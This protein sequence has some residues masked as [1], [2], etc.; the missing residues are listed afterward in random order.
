MPKEWT[1]R[2]GANLTTGKSPYD[3][4]R[5][6]N[7]IVEVEPYSYARDGA[8]IV[9]VGG[10]IS[11]SGLPNLPVSQQARVEES[12]GDQ[13]TIDTLASL[14]LWIDP[15]APIF[16]DV[17][18]NTAATTGDPVGNV[19]CYATGN[20]YTQ[21]NAA[22]KPTLA[23][24][25]VLTGGWTNTL[26][27][28]PGST[29]T[30]KLIIATDDGI[31]VADA[32]L[33]SSFTIRITPTNIRGIFAG[34][35]TAGDIA[36]LKSYAVAEGAVDDNFSGITNFSNY[37]RNLSFLLSIPSSLDTSSGENFSL[38]WYYCSNLTSF[39]L[40]DTSSGTNFNRA[41]E[42]CSGLTS[43]PLLN[44]S[45]VIN[46]QRCWFGCSSLVSFPLIDTSSG[47]N[48]DETWSTCPGLTSFP[49]LDV[50]SGTSFTA[51]WRNCSNLT[52]FPLLDTS[53]GTN[54]SFTWQN[55]SGLTSF[56]LLDVSSGEDFRFAW[57]DCSSLAS[58]PLLDVSSGTDF[59]STWRDCSSLANFPAN[60]FD[61]CSATSFD[62]AFENTA[63]TQT[64]I[65]N[66]LVSIESNGTSNGTFDQS[67][68]SAPSSVGKDAIDS[69]VSRG[70]TI[71][72][73]GGYTGRD[74]SALT[75]LPS[76]RQ[77]EL[78]DAGI[79]QDQI[80]ALASAS[81]WIDAY[82]VAT[83]T[84]YTTPATTGDPVASA[85]DNSTGNLWTQSNAANRPALAA[86]P[87]IAGNYT[88]TLTGTT[89]ADTSTKLIIATTDGILVADANIPASLTIK[90][91]NNT[92][93]WISGDLSSAEID[94]IKTL[95]VAEGAV[96]DD[97]SG[98]TNFT[99]YFRD[100]SFLLTITS[101]LD[102]S[103]GTNFSFAWA[104]CTGLTSFP[105]LDTSSGTNFTHSW[106][107]CTSLTS[108]P[109]LDVSSGTN[110]SRTW[111]N[112]TSLT[113]FPLLDVSS[114]TDFSRTWLD[115][116]SLASFPANFFDGCSATNF[117]DAFLNTALNQTSIDNI[118]V[119]IE[120]NGTNN[121]VFR[122]GGG[123]AP[124]ATGEAAIDSLR[125]RGWN[126]TVTGG[127]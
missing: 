116:T 1:Y 92:V 5:V 111:Q 93:Y 61:G 73:T 90:N 113:A 46:F 42:G 47:T 109:I 53:S 67:G 74:F 108:F 25:P 103:F 65:D 123:S 117:T 57:V 21:S 105:L 30:Q 7:D 28:A 55:C 31:L 60:F 81:I 106:I 11:F 29:G 35:L 59:R 15:Y 126:V 2:D 122:Q 36:R 38:T 96:D 102:T 40:I 101:S 86:G 91:V 50:S 9:E 51:T 72:V 54:F 6:D 26:E 64:S 14:D 70:W 71:S 100:F 33:A 48:F 45:L 32:N 107:G 3:Y 84:G 66:I 34:T 110:F 127:Y 52:S 124:S 80:D 4:K 115:C 79:T 85:Y 114:G 16:T 18:G 76:A 95:A 77:T 24:G 125:G 27:G 10:G 44:T 99:S 62:R 56:P 13:A 8:D 87:V 23:A 88:K 82:G 12:A 19:Q 104:D 63:L 68:G 94:E 78:R 41:W 97:F 98:I 121:G 58:F 118:L 75:N 89:T 22:S 119:S 112:C 43:F 20:D 83:D 17:A 49:L 69:L 120:S 37:F 39:P